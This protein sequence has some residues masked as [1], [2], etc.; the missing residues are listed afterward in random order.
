MP[1]KP[2][3]QRDEQRGVSAAELRQLQGQIRE[4]V[5]QQVRIVDPKAIG[6]FT[7]NLKSA[8]AFFS[9]WHDK[10]KDG[11]TFSDAWG[12]AGDLRAQLL[13]RIGPEGM[14]G[15][16]VPDVIPAAVIPKK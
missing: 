6:E 4:A 16:V 15:V 10:F 7:I 11:G 2:E 8:G 5:L 12:K 13:Q 9:D 3:E 1:K 14:P